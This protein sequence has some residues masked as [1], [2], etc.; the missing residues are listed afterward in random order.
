[1]TPLSFDAPLQWISVKIY[2][3]L[4][5]RETKSQWAMCQLSLMPMLPVATYRCLHHLAVHIQTQQPHQ[6]QPSNWKQNKDWL[7][8]EDRVKVTTNGLYKV[9]HRLSIA[10]KMYDLEWPVREIKGHWFLK[11]RKNGEVQLS[12]SNDT[13]VMWTVEGLGALASTH[14]RHWESPPLFFFPL[15][16]PSPFPIPP[17]PSS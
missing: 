8:V 5:L 9:V 1:M 7:V 4:I 13:D 12:Y 2:I 15:P 11:C 14:F 6:Q 3:N 10:H 17:S 16:L